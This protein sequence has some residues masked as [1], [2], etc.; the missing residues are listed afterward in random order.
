MHQTDT[1]TNVGSND[2]LGPTALMGHI[3]IARKPCGK[4]S[5]SSWDDKGSEKDTAKSIARWV[6]RGDKVEKMPRYEGDAQQEW[7]CNRND[8]CACRDAGL[9]ALIEPLPG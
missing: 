6:M 5:A 9:R 4:V 2:G 1:P 8:P 7:C 3:Y